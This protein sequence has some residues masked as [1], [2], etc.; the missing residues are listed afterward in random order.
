MKNLTLL[1]ILFLPLVVLAQD[2]R[3][4]NSEQAISWDDLEVDS[5][6]TPVGVL[7][8]PHDVGALLVDGNRTYRLQERMIDL[9]LAILND[10]VVVT[11]SDFIPA[12]NI[13]AQ[14]H[15]LT[16]VLRTATYNR[17]TRSVTT[18]ASDGGFLARDYTN[19]DGK[20]LPVGYGRYPGAPTA[21][22]P[23]I[24]G[25]HPQLGTNFIGHI[26]G[27]ASS[28]YNPAG[29]TL[30]PS[31][32][33]LY[34]QIPNSLVGFA[35]GVNRTLAYSNGSLLAIGRYVYDVS[36]DEPSTSSYHEIEASSDPV[37]IAAFTDHVVAV[38]A[39]EL[40]SLDT[41]DAS[42][43]AIKV[44]PKG[45]TATSAALHP[46]NRLLVFGTYRNSPTVLA[47]DAQLNLVEAYS[48]GQG[49]GDA[50]ATNANGLIWL[51]ITH[52]D[53]AAQLL[54]LVGGLDAH[55]LATPVVGLADQLQ[56]YTD[57]PLPDTSGMIKS[58]SLT[59]TR[60]VINNEPRGDLTGIV[61]SFGH[62]YTYFDR[63]RDFQAVQRSASGQLLEIGIDSA[64]IRQYHLP[65]TRSY[66]GSYWIVN[67][68][69]RRLERI[70]TN[71][72][73]IATLDFPSNHSY[74]VIRTLF[75]GGAIIGVQFSAPSA[76]TSPSYNHSR[77]DG[78]GEIR[79]QVP[80][81]HCVVGGLLRNSSTNLVFRWQTVSQGNEDMI[82]FV[83][84]CNTSHQYVPM[85]R[86]L[87]L[88]T[89]PVVLEVDSFPG[90]NYM[91][92]DGVQSLNRNFTD[93]GTYV[94]TFT[95]ANGQAY[96][97]SLEVTN[98]P[99]L[100]TL[101]ASNPTVLDARC[102]G[103]QANYIIRLRQPNRLASLTYNG[104]AKALEDS[105]PQGSQELV[106][107][108]T[109]GCVYNLAIESDIVDSIQLTLENIEQLEDTAITVTL[110]SGYFDRYNWSDGVMTRTNT[111]TL[112]L[113][114]NLSVQG[115]NTY[116]NCPTT[117]LTLSLV[118]SQTSAVDPS[119]LTATRI[120]AQTLLITYP[121]AQAS[122]VLTLYDLQGRVL[123]TQAIAGGST[124]QFID[125][126]LF[127]PTFDVPGSGFIDLRE[128]GKRMGVGR[129]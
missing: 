88:C 63:V 67:Q 41:A 125:L 127:S 9:R 98:K 36:D 19:V 100:N 120:G 50:I 99:E 53:S 46:T 33:Y 45:Y 31:S 37:G 5:S 54:Q 28:I 101:L 59:Y 71:G 72:H 84:E 109:S 129:F 122:R 86:S 95:D 112:N 43:K 29:K 44:L 106:L 20:L 82:N 85:P 126:S 56:T 80:Q 40:I 8:L 66:D 22:K 62:H 123:L 70:D 2:L 3:I 6:G 68:H 128:G 121:S 90:F 89:T 97:Q 124:E 51:G 57:Y 79:E 34:A 60:L 110:S 69:L 114:V 21:S 77:I 27:S 11:G 48:Y 104:E 47:F 4:A 103:R 15:D 117:R 23:S 38:T 18:R 83:N 17:A 108:T 12:P 118:S 35:L 65:P 25:Q 76:I 111:R 102:A 91:W 49:N 42:I 73:V 7:T 64:G 81:G 58:Y 30:R 14:Y 24:I 116:Y 119:G 1:S 10:E 92:S 75:D 61:D 105:I 13:S 93:T 74:S 96:Q 52:P 115:I 107:T 39:R 32:F 78:F 87:N 16:Y 94:L 55:P 26:P 113:P